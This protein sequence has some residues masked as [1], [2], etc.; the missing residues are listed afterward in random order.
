MGRKIEFN[1]DRALDRAM[2]E[3]W[4]KGYTNTSLRDLLKTMKIGEGSF[5]NLVGGKKDLYL[6]CIKRYNDQVSARRIDAMMTADTASAGVRSFFKMILD[7]L[8]DKNMPR[9]CLMAGSLTQEV[10]AEEELQ[11][12]V[13]EKTNEFEEKFYERFETGKKAGDLPAQFSG[14]VAA[15]I[16]VTYL[17]GFF[18]VIRILKTRAEMEVQ[19]ERL[20][21]GL[22]L[23]A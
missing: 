23:K 6:L 10:L 7:D 20:L 2:L 4:K 14:R 17:Q 19:I 12:Y 22:G 5:Y 13:L 9:I 18:R 11:E 21:S 1:L 15:Q 16:L 8:D 3:F